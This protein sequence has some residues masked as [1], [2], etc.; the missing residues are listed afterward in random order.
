MHFSKPS[1]SVVG[2]LW[3]VLG[4]LL[5]S[6]LLVPLRHQLD[7]SNV[8]LLYVLAVV[9]MAVSYGRGPAVLAALVCS[10]CYAYFF[11]P[12]HFSLAISEAQ[13]MLAAVIM[14]VVALIVSHLTSRLKQH[15]DF[16]QRKSRESTKLYELSQAL[17]G[18]N[19]PEAVITLARQF[20]AALFPARAVRIFLPGECDS[21]T[22]PVSPALL[23]ECIKR[24][25]LLSRPLG[26]GRFYAL[27]PLTAASGIQGVLGFEA[28]TATLGSEDAIK[29][30]DTV[31]SVVAV[32]ME[33][34]HFAAMARENEVKHA[35][36]ALR[37]AILSALSHDLR[38]PLTALVGMA[39]TVAL[40]KAPPERQKPMLDA[41]RQQALSIS[42]Q[43]TN[44][45]DMAKLSAGRF[46]LQADWQ[47]IEEVLGATLQQV[48]AHWPQRRLVVDMAPDLPPVNIDAV[49]IERAL[50]NLIENAIKYSPAESVVD[51]HVVGRGAQL[52]IEVCDAG[53]GI[54]EIDTAR[55]FEPFRRGKA[56]SEIPGVGLGLAIAQ[57]IVEAHDGSIEARPRPG[58]GSCF[59]ISLPVGNPPA[60]SVL[61]GEAG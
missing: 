12:P 21:A 14:L 58:G 26:D 22:D 10:L 35:A 28:D 16:A 51:I 50:W 46:E 37:N 42:Q 45:L 55:L 38:T 57:R 31:V 2:Y 41:I 4:T 19:T 25:Q 6:L 48:A 34:C 15:A 61:A 44:L 27:V 13:N 53:S 52:E 17:S 30:L 47:P 40:G 20:F 33:R 8:A 18:A 29:Y 36:E 60:F 59:C 39:E 24:R 9:M 7:L 32:A 11:V 49:L 5:G 54:G 56:E 23:K 3:A 1:L 43:M